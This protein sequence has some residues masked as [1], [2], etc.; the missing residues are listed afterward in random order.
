[1]SLPVRIALLF[2]VVSSAHGQSFEDGVGSFLKGDYARASAIWEGIGADDS[3]AS[4][5]LALMYAQGIGI[6][7][8]PNKAAQLMRKARD[9]GSPVARYLI[10]RDYLEQDEAGEPSVEAIDNLYI[11]AVHNLS[12][13]HI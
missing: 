1:M 10:G 2:V 9:L 5:N 12:L 3:R 8:D 11:A 7:R 6:D 13:I 4:L